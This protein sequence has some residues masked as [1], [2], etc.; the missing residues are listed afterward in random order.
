MI[1]MPN[2]WV[3]YI[4][5]TLSNNLKKNMLKLELKQPDLVGIV[6]RL[7]LLR[8]LWRSHLRLRDGNHLPKSVLL[9]S[10]LAKFKHRFLC[11]SDRVGSSVT[12]LTSL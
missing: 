6:D 10:P 11:R 1:C 9:A 8:R 4:H 12:C 2:D 3:K 5:Q 7:L